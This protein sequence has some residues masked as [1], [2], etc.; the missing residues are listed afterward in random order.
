MEKESVLAA[1]KLLEKEIPFVLLQMEK[2]F[3]V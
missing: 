1:E 2:E 3:M